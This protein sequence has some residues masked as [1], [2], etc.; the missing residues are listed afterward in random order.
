MSAVADLQEL[1]LVSL[2][3]VA[4]ADCHCLLLL[5]LLY[6]ECFNRRVAARGQECRC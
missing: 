5:L 3:T 6:L 2:L 1:M 4:A